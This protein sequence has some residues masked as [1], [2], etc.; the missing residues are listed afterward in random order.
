MKTCLDLIKNSLFVTGAI[1][2]GEQVD[3]DLA[4]MVMQ[5]LNAM[6]AEW[7]GTYIDNQKYDQYFENDFTRDHITLGSYYDD[8][9]TYSAGV[10]YNANS[11]IVESDNYLTYSWDIDKQLVKV[12]GNISER[13]SLIEG[14][15]LKFGNINLPLNIKQ[16]S[17]FRN[18][19]VNNIA[20]I[21][22]TAYID[23]QFPIQSIYLFPNM[24]VGQGL[25]V[26][27]V[28]YFKEY[29]NVGDYYIDLPELWNAQVF[30]LA[31]RIAPMLG[32]NLPPNTVIQAHSSLKHLKNRNFVN[33]IKTCQNDFQTGGM[34]FNFWAGV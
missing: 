10:F 16:Y 17:E 26:I 24:Q 1:A 21:P 31:M 28:P 19:P 33:N 15:V 4:K 12:T 11:E 13:P 6:R 22:S 34:G 7:S 32:V 9:M 23:N 8:S 3:P 5:T 25:R 27:G 29:E 18:I 30:N 20:S 2:F 14:I